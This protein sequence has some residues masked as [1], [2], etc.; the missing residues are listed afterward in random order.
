MNGEMLVSVSAAGSPDRRQMFGVVFD[1]TA[2]GERVDVTGVCDVPVEVFGLCP[3]R[4]TITFLSL[5][6][7][8]S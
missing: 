2:G 7:V 8:R 5:A 3:A 6:D 4:L 1:L